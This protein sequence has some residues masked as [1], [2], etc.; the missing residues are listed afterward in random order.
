[1]KNLKVVFK[2]INEMS[3]PLYAKGE[4]L[5]L[6]EK[7]ISCPEDKEVC[8][9]LVRDMTQL[10]FTFLQK[11][12]FV[13]EKHLSTQFNCSGCSGLIKFALIAPE[14]NLS[15]DK[16]DGTVAPLD[17]GLRQRYDKVIKS[18]L[19]DLLKQEKVDQF[20]SYCQEIQVEEGHTLITQGQQNC[21]LYIVL[22]GE[23]S[24]VDNNLVLATLQ[25]G[26]LCGEMSYLGADV[27]LASVR[28]KSTGTVL[29]IEGEAFSRLLSDDVKVQSYM[30]KL[31]AKRLQKTN[32][33]RSQDI[34][35]CM[36]GRIDEILPAELFQIFHMHQKT[37]VLKM[38]LAGGSAH[39]SFRE[40][41][42][43][44]ASYGKLD[45]EDAIFKILAEKTGW[46]RFITGLSA[47]EMRAAEIGD[48]MMLLME[49]VKRVDE[50]QEF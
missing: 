27:A 14:E 44:N 37:G 11:P 20:L 41:C 42:I 6:S 3:C 48:F 24:I 50:D 19:L 15:E 28:A 4:H 34:E 38:D 36:R 31:L 10:L 22:S 39:V 18:S 33:V 25:Q 29:A 35:A 7:T 12:P 9:I 26:E 17:K 13:L 30:A 47:E 43:I 23:F 8:L 40:G 21:N 32:K 5:Y 49:G 2:I 45:N 1:M 46:Y 16:N